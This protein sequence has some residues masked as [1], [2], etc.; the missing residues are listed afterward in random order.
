MPG[1]EAQ[2]AKLNLQQDSVKVFM[3]ILE[4]ILKES[5]TTYPFLLELSQR[6][7]TQL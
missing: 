4:A 1:Q 2:A 3:D 6:I 5:P 7:A